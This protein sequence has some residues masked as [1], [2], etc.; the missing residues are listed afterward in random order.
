MKSITLEEILGQAIK[1]EE[2]SYSFYQK[3][4]G[5]VL[6]AVTKD[7]LEF[8][9]QEELR[10]KAFLKDYLKGSLKEGVRDLKEAHDGKILE[11]FS[12]PEASET[13]NQKDAFLVAARREQL[14]HDFYLKLADLHGAGPVREL[15]TKLA[16]EELAHK[17]KAEYLYVNAAF[18]QTAGG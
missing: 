2:L 8:L 18:P 6:D 13:L 15:L 4:K 16:N 1:F 17:E 9:S 5:I 11:A 14:S 12:A 3:M 7:T 10:H